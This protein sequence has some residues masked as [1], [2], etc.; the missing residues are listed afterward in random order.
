MGVSLTKTIQLW[1][2]HHDYGNPHILHMGLSEKSVPHS[3]HWF[4]I[5]FRKI[6][7]NSQAEIIESAKT[8]EPNAIMRGPRCSKR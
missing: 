5:I 7:M 2:Y 8:A 1:G 3:I 4:I 6:A